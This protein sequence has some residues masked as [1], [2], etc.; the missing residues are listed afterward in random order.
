M[1]KKKQIIK[2]QQHFRKIKY[3]KFYTFEKF[4]K[5]EE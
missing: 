2:H 3:L 4:K 1:L 5:N